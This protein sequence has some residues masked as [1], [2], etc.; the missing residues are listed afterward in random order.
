MIEIALGIEQASEAASVGFVSYEQL[1]GRFIEA[2]REAGLEDEGQGVALWAAFSFHRNAQNGFTGSYKGAD[3]ERPWPTDPRQIPPAVLEVPGT[4]SR[5][6]PGPKP[7]D[8]VSLTPCPVA[9][10]IAL[11]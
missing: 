1:L 6:R 3:P 11:I 5:S 9:S 10:G 2:L 8:F 7:G 4:A